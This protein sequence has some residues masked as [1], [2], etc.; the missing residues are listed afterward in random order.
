MKE[1]FEGRRRRKEV[2][3]KKNELEKEKMEDGYEEKNKKD[4]NG[5]IGN[6]KEELKVIKKKENI[7]SR[8]II[9]GRKKE[10]KGDDGCDGE[11]EGIEK[12]RCDG[13]KKKGKDKIEDGEE[14]E[15]KKSER[16]LIED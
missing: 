16:G 8:N 13:R 11:K 14:N 15:R 9:L 5:G 12:R 6:R 3:E 10:D 1:G 4:K 7:G 2:L